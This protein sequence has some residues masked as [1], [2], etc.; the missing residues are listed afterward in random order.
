MTD[1][2]EGRPEDLPRLREIQSAAL[3]EPAPSLLDAAADGPLQLLVIADGGLVGYAIVVTD[4]N[5]VAYVP[6]VAVAPAEQGNAYG[7]QLLSQLV[8]TLRNAGYDQLRLTARLEDD[9]AHAF[10]EAHGF[11]PRERV[12]GQF[13]SGDGRLFVRPLG[14]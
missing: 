13:E 12:S 1:I 6:E 10:Y 9:R 7:S 5:A 4:G 11:E 3:P 14:E 8:E 2:R